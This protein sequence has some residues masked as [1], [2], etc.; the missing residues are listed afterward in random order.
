MQ[1]VSSATTLLWLKQFSHCYV[2]HCQSPWGP[3]GAQHPRQFPGLPALLE[4]PCSAWWLPA[5]YHNLLQHQQQ[6]F[7]NVMKSDTSRDFGRSLSSLPS[8]A[9]NS[10]RHCSTIKATLPRYR[11]QALASLY[12]SYITLLWKTRAAVL[13]IPAADQLCSV[14]SWATYFNAA[15]IEPT[16]CVVRPGCPHEELTARAKIRLFISTHPEGKPVQ[17]QPEAAGP[18]TGCA[19]FEHSGGF[20][21]SGGGQP[22]TGDW[23]RCHAWSP[24]FPKNRDLVHCRAAL[25]VKM[26][27]V[28]DV[29]GRHWFSSRTAVVGRSSNELLERWS[30]WMKSRIIFF[31][32][33]FWIEPLLLAFLKSFWKVRFWKPIYFRLVC[34]SN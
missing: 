13:H 23:A 4:Q 29:C 3:L 24:V 21:G 22:V 17:F 14:Q 31:F 11:M 20:P 27:Y 6:P 5:E 25:G 28:S 19:V 15:A 2:V 34:L 26:W 1:G 8:T 16:W 9:S 30:E 33:F 12:Q 7:N 32:S 18:V 10:S